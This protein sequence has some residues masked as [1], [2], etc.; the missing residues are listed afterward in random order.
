MLEAV[1]KDKIIYSFDIKNEYGNEEIDISEEYRKAGQTGLLTCEECGTPVY[2]KAGKT[3]IPHFAHKDSNRSCFFKE[4]KNESEEQKKGKILLYKWL[5]NQYD[6]VYIDKKYENRR[7]NISVVTDSGIIALQFIRNERS[8]SEWDEK[9]IDY[10]NLGIKDLYFFST[11]D[12]EN[13]N[14][15]EL[16]RKIVQKYSNDMTIKMI[17]T[18]KNELMLMRYIDIND[19]QDKLFYSKLFCKTYNIYDTKLNIDGVIQS[20]FEDEYLKAFNVHKIIAKEELEKQ[21]KI[22][23]R[24]ISS[25]TQ[26]QLN[27]FSYGEK[28]DENILISKQEIKTNFLPKKVK[29]D[30][31]KGSCEIDDNFLEKVRTK[32]TNSNGVGTKELE[33]EILNYIFS[34]GEFEKEWWIGKTDPIRLIRC[35]YCGRFFIADYCTQ[36]KYHHG[37]CRNCDN[38][39]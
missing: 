29:V 16:F 23:E 6:Y 19:D 18:G 35:K 31:V 25:L 26:H 8:L 22:K 34:N 4:N 14:S 2:L 30:G 39:N 38:E 7:A 27:I 11:N 3:R 13:K 9:R 28:T 20:D 36:V 1:Y 37:T 21:S 32:Y 33:K 10:I 12:F 24:I 5:C 15:G 17:D